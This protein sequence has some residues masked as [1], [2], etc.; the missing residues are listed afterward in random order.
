MYI[1]QKDTREA[2]LPTS[3]ALLLKGVTVPVEV[4]IGYCM[5]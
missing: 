1:L 2:E 4:N 3:V 5:C